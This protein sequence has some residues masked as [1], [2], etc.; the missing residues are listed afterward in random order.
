MLPFFRKN[1]CRNSNALLT[2][3]SNLKKK[4]RKEGKENKKML[5]YLKTRKVSRGFIILL[6]TFKCSVIVHSG[7]QGQVSSPS[8]LDSQIA[9]KIYWKGYC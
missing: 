4:G 9:C 5:A 2:T 1:P 3:D 8:S 6:F 7:K